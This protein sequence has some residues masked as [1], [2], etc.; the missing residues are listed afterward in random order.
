MVQLVNKIACK[1]KLNIYC[2][3]FGRNKQFKTNK[4][5]NIFGLG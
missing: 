4:S 3:P 2:K 1:T 5:I